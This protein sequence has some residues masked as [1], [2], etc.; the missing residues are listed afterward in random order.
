[1]QSGLVKHAALTFACIAVVLA[2]IAQPASAHPSDAST[3]A[4][5]LLV[6]RKG[7]QV[8]DAAAQAAT[9]E[10][11]TSESQRKI[12]A[13]EVLDALGMPLDSADINAANSDRYHE[14]GFTVRL[15]QAFTNGSAIGAVQV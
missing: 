13:T 7:L 6:D 2:A 3:L 5:D 14:V 9:Y 11:R 8:L 1:M 10:Q 15:R 12:V 4:L